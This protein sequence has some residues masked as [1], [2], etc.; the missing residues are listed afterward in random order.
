MINSVGGNQQMAVGHEQ[1]A[2]ANAQRAELDFLLQSRGLRIEDIDLLPRRPENL[3]RRQQ[4][5]AVAEPIAAL[6]ARRGRYCR[7]ADRRCRSNRAYSRW[8]SGSRRTRRA[9][10]PRRPAGLERDCRSR[11]SPRLPAKGFVPWRRPRH[12]PAGYR[13]GPRTAGRDRT[14]RD[15]SR[16]PVGVHAGEDCRRGPAGTGSTS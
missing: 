2:A 15:S 11:W 8:R 5:A 14:G 3:S 6:R 9:S 12:K 4:A 13:R 7:P 16:A 10:G 1:I